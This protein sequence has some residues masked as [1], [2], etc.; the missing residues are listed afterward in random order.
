MGSGET[1]NVNRPTGV[2]GEGT[3]GEKD[4]ASGGEEERGVANPEGTSV[5]GVEKEQTIRRL[6]DGPNTVEYR[7]I[8]GGGKEGVDR[9]INAY[10]VTRGQMGKG[11]GGR[12]RRRRPNS[13]GK[14]GHGRRGRE[15]NESRREDKTRHR[16]D[17]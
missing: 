13:M 1:V 17:G 3:G 10:D 5:T 7:H 16:A 12:G 2:A 15:R 11:A 8:D 6:T 9:R 14:R 4:V